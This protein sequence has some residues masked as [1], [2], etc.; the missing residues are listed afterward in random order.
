MSRCFLDYFDLFYV[1]PPRHINR[2]APENAKH[3]KG[4]PG[5]VLCT[6]GRS[7][8]GERT[9]SSRSRPRRHD[10][11][12]RIDDGQ[13]HQQ[14]RP[15][16]Q[17]QQRTSHGP[18][19]QSQ[20]ITPPTLDSSPTAATPR[21]PSPPSPPAQPRRRSTPP[22]PTPHTAPGRPPAPPTHIYHYTPITTDRP[23]EAGPRRPL[24]HW[25]GS[26]PAQATPPT[27]Q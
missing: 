27:V 23:H 14:P 21:R 8:N 15:A 2:L 10:Q 18:R 1:F 22:R 24:D 17:A 25:T 12:P 11:R 26:D 7:P 16:H 4:H 20:Q 6:W 19:H 9:H 5:N 13:R 3:P